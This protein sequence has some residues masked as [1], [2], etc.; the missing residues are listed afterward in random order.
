MLHC[1]RG[2]LALMANMPTT[3][4]PFFGSFLSAFR[5]HGASLQKTAAPSPSTTTSTSTQS[6]QY[7]TQ[8]N[9]AASSA[10]NGP[11][12]LPIASQARSIITKAGPTTGATSVAIQAGHFQTSRQHHTASAYSPTSTSPSAGALTPLQTRGRRGSDSSSEGFRET[13]LGAD[14]WYIGGRTAG[15]EERVYK[16]SMVKRPRSIDRLS[17]DRMS[18]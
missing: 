1:A 4:R 11:L 6:T 9:T 5:A 16:L 18:L 7:S 13:S 15:G 8:S 2:R 17:L 3:N 12:A 10:P 14:K